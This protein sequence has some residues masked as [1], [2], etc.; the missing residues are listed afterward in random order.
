M[1]K[2]K[3]L[4]QLRKSSQL[5]SI[6][7]RRQSPAA[8]SAIIPFHRT[9]SVLDPTHP[10]A[11]A[12]RRFLPQTSVNAFNVVATP[13][14]LLEPPTTSLQPP[15]NIPIETW[16]ERISRSLNHPTTNKI[17]N[18]VL[19]P[20]KLINFQQ[21]NRLSM[22]LVTVVGKKAT[23]KKKVVRLRIINKIKNAFNFA[24]VRGAKIVDGKVVLD[25]EAPRQHLIHQGWT[26]S[27]YPVLDVYRM[28]FTQLIPDV[29]MAMERIHKKI[30][31]L[32]TSWARE[33]FVRSC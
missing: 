26:Y 27:I 9:D 3:E 15:F 10:A 22:S 28:P 12:P 2:C 21:P 7:F 1:L 19:A 17:D 20:V 32:E 18:A 29:L 25:K 8:S 6:L 13:F 16:A 14:G 33:S 5:S 23:S 11:K 31:S 4:S 24:I 30:I